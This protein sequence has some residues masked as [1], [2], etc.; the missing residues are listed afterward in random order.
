MEPTTFIH[1]IECPTS[2][3][4]NWYVKKCLKALKK[5]GVVVF[6]HN[7]SEEAHAIT[8]ILHS[9]LLYNPQFSAISDRG[10][11]VFF[12]LDSVKCVVYTGIGG[13]INASC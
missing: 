4:G 5:R 10:R 7:E 8:S 3:K 11:E 12:S 6:D 1:G 13:G 9:V 2:A